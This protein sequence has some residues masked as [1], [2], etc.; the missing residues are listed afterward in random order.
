MAFAGIQLSG[1]SSGQPSGYSGGHVARCQRRRVIR[2]SWSESH[3]GREH[4]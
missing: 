1:P 3:A 2:L 4:L